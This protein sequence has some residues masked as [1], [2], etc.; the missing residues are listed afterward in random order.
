MA[1][2]VMN[3]C[4]AYVGGYDFTTD[5][6]K[7]SVKADVEDKD[8]TTFGNNGWKA[9]RGGLREVSL[10]LEG[11]WQSDTADAVDPEAHTYLGVAHRAVTVSQ[12]GQDGDTAYFFQGGSFNY[13]LFGSVG[14]L[15]PFTLG[16]KG[17]SKYGL[18]RG[19]LAKAKALVTGTGPTGSAVELGAAGA[20]QFVYAVVH[21]FSAGTTVTLKIESDDDPGFASPT[22]VV[23]LAPITSAG[24]TWIARIPGPIT[25][26]HYRFNV[27]SITGSFT[28]AAAIGIGS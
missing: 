2:F 1:E 14:D 3:D 27:E 13:E 10:D 11:Y 8:A 22:E 9:R 21:V 12:T 26:T 28:L 24:G 5:V 20:G 18:V 23:E 17:T 19:K 16:H 15:T 25:D 7:I 4:T 6:N